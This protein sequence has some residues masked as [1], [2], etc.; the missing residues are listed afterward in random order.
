MSCNCGAERMEDCATI[1]ELLA[2]EL[3]ELRGGPPTSS[4]AWL[5]LTVLRAKGKQLYHAT[6]CLLHP[7]EC[8]DA[9]K[10]DTA[11][12]IARLRVSDEGQEGLRAFFARRAPEWMR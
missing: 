2:D 5:D 10:R 3:A 12:L 8:R 11:A 1:A 9:L 7:T 4:D 6:Y